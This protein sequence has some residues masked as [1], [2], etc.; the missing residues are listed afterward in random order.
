M[1]GMCA[2]T[3]SEQVSDIGLQSLTETPQTV[4]SK[5]S[6]LIRTSDGFMQFYADLCRFM[7]VY[8]D[9]CCRHRLA[10]FN[11]NAPNRFFEG[12]DSD[13]HVGRFYAVLCRTPLGRSPNQGPKTKPPQVNFSKASTVIRTSDGPQAK[14]RNPSHPKSIFRRRRQ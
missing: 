11:R 3:H 2:C 7:Q 5:A 9:F 6:A 13:S 10:K 12:V 14:V 1:L 4:F 8:A